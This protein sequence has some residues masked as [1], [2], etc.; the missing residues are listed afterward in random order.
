M[1]DELSRLKTWWAG[2][3]PDPGY[4]A[5]DEAFADDVLAL[6]YRCEKADRRIAELERELEEARKALVWL[7]DD[8]TK[9]NQSPYEAVPGDVKAAVRRSKSAARAAGEER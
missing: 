1:S 5:G 7:W 2:L 4:C 8:W 6:M 3:H 9:E